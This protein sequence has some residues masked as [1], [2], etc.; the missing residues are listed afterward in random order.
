MIGYLDKRGAARYSA[1]STR[2][3]DLER[4]RGNL[5]YHR[6]GRK[7]VF[8]VKDLDRWLAR[9]RVDVEGVRL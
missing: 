7:V 2:L 5:P 3:L 4:A 8:A 6:V 9:F 1:V